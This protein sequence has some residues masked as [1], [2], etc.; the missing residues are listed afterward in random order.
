MAT[1]EEH[2]ERHGWWISVGIVRPSVKKIN[3][4]NDLN[5][6]RDLVEIIKEDKYIDYNTDFFNNRNSCQ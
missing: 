3:E 5:E 6:I 4:L 1:L 2:P